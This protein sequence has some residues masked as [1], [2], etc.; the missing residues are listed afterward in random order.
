[1]LR[2]LAGGRLSA[3]LISNQ[4][5]FARRIRYRLKTPYRDAATYVIFEP[6]DFIVHVLVLDGATTEQS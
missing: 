2:V 4:L 5:L 3:V 6:R 1:M